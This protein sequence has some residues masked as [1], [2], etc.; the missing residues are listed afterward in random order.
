MKRRRIHTNGDT[1]GQQQQRYRRG[2]QQQLLPHND[3]SSVSCWMDFESIE[4]IT[5]FSSSKDQCTNQQIV[6]TSI[7]SSTT[8]ELFMERL[9]REIIEPFRYTMSTQIQLLD[10]DQSI[11]DAMDRR[12]VIQKRIVCGYN[13]VSQLL[14]DYAAATRTDHKRGVLVTAPMLIVLVNPTSTELSNHPQQQQQQHRTSAAAITA[15]MV[16]HIPLLAHEVHVPLLLLPTTYH[17]NN[18]NQRGEWIETSAKLATLFT[19]EGGGGGNGCCSN[20][21]RNHFTL[22]AF[23]QRLE[24]QQ[25]HRCESDVPTRSVMHLENTSFRDDKNDSSHIH[26][27]IDSFVNYIQ[28]KIE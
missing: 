23:T 12:K 25:L 22:I 14:F 27:T 13:D 9:Q 19:G 17:V 24:Q 7:A 16:Q 5:N 26:N 3:V 4:S 18:N 10:S 15:S 28:G 2:Q 11:H 20:K 6:H 8:T 21:N 1:K